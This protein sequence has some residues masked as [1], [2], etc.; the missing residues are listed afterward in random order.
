MTQTPPHRRA[1]SAWG[2]ARLGLVIA[3]IVIAILLRPAMAAIGPLLDLIQASIPLSNAAASLLTALPMAMIGVGALLGAELRQRVSEFWGIALGAMLITAFTALRGVWWS[4]TG[5]IVSAIVIGA[6]IAMVQVLMPS[7]VKRHFGDQSPRVMGLYSTGI[8]GGA[9]AGAATAAPL[10][11]RLDWQWGLAIWWIFGVATLLLWS[12]AHA[13]RAAVLARQAP[14]PA[15]KKPAGLAVNAD[16]APPAET[17]PAAQRPRRSSFT[18]GL[19]GAGEASAR[20]RAQRK[21]LASTLRGW[22][23]LVFFGLCTGA[24]TLI[25]AWL[26][27]YYTAQGLS[28]RDAGFLLGVYTIAEVA[29]GLLISAFIGRVPDRRGPLLVA[30]ALVVVGLVLLILVPMWQPAVIS[31]ILG[32]GTGALFA[33]SLILMMDH[34]RDPEHAGVLADFV[35]GGGYLIAAGTPLVAGVL[36][37]AFADLRGAWGLMLF[38]TILLIVMATRFSPK[39]YDQLHVEP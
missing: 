12:V 10:A 4:P 34:A 31:S 19:I 36:R 32:V 37:D 14:A 8:M 21:A 28:L 9:A 5:L 23:L 2:D 38:G 16:D 25:L 17:P 6:G 22:E 24:F 13:R 30:L 15:S 29:V 27:P 18:R 3:V 7:F 20:A 11:G 1:T 26:P 39:S 33:L 35:Q